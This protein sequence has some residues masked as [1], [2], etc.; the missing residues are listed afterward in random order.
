VILGSFIQASYPIAYPIVPDKTRLPNIK[1][2]TPAMDY[3]NLRQS[4]CKDDQALTVERR[5]PNF[6]HY[7]G[8]GIAAPGFIIGTGEY[9]PWCVA[10]PHFQ[11][12]NIF[13]KSHMDKI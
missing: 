1:L 8:C 4:K 10:P 2:Q 12:S 9:L 5:P 3:E 7:G 11:H 6:P 13:L